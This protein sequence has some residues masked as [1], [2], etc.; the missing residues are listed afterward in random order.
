MATARQCDSCNGFWQLMRDRMVADNSI[1]R[2]RCLAR[3]RP[4]LTETGGLQTRV[5]GSAGQR[6]RGA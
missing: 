4:I 6:E 2:K 3:S 5:G 1:C